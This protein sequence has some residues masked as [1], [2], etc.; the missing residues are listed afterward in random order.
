MFEFMESKNLFCKIFLKGI[1]ASFAYEYFMNV[2]KLTSSSKEI[3]TICE[4]PGSDFSIFNNA[5]YGKMLHAERA[6]HVVML[7]KTKYH[8]K[9]D[10]YSLLMLSYR[11]IGNGTI[12]QFELSNL[13]HEQVDKINALFERK[14]INNWI[15]NSKLMKTA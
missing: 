2:R 12:I 9:F 3:A 7:F 1:K 15:K 8:K 11:E 6:K 13:P 5:I 4:E 10:H 14:F